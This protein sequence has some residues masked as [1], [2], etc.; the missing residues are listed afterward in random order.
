MT[1]TRNATTAAQARYGQWTRFCEF[2]AAASTTI[3]DATR[4]TTPTL[5]SMGMTA[6]STQL[7]AH[8]RRLNALQ[9]AAGGQG[10]TS[11]GTSVYKTEHRY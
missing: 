2:T 6:H 5:C 8:Q 1:I 11:K 3:M 9:S 7:I 4:S 10:A